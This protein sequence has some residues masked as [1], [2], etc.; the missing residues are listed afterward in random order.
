VFKD[1]SIYT[2]CSLVA[3]ALSFL[4]LPLFTRYLTPADYGVLA[5]FLMV[6][7]IIPGF[8]SLGLKTATYKYYFQYINKPKLFRIINTT[9]VIVL[10]CLFVFGFIIISL[11]A[12]IITLKIFDSKLSESLIQLAFVYGCLEYFFGYFTFLLTAQKKA[13]VFGAVTIS[14][15]VLDLGLTTYFL[16]VLKMDYYAKVYALL[17]S[18]GLIFLILLFLMRNTFILG[19]SLRLAKMSIKMTSPTLLSSVLG[20]VNSSFDKI[21]I[22]KF[23]TLSKLAYYNFGNRFAAIFQ[24][25]HH[26]VQKVW[27]PYFFE[28]IFKKD[29]EELKKLVEKF[30][31]MLFFF[32]GVGFL[33]IY[34]SEELIKIMTTKEFYVSMYITPFF[35]LN[36]VVGM[37]G[38]LS[39]NQI[40]AKEKL[41][42]QFPVSLFSIVTNVSLNFLLIPIYGIYG[43]I[44]G[45][46]IASV[47]SEFALFYFAN[48]ALPLPINKTRIFL[49]Y[50]YFILS[51]MPAFWFMGTDMSFITKVSLKLI[52]FIVFIYF[53]IALKLVEYKQLTYFKNKLQV[54]LLGET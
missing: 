23:H 14:R 32:M 16:V 5:L 47:V 13:A 25:S 36:Y 20:I 50:G 27:S 10:I 11:F 46:I 30:E 24:L 41:I 7:G 35:V 33:I 42:Y 22:N 54:K 12:D 39:V 51:A 31:L 53:F 26:S 28:N 15:L 43:A 17:V 1:L 49:M 34:F 52:C 8:M 40:V 44:A 48:K 6:A 38:E 21:L 29:E 18:Y 37:M 2:I 3:Q 4:V 19:F 9:N 45:T